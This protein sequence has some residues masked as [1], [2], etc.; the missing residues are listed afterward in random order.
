[1]QKKKKKKKKIEIVGGGF[2]SGFLITVSYYWRDDFRAKKVSGDELCLNYHEHS[3][4]MGRDYMKGRRESLYLIPC[5]AH[6]T[7]ERHPC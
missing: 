2:A 1:M 4:Q 6:T 3:T 5:K 7:W